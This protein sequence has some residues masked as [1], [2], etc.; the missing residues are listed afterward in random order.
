VR[1]EIEMQVRDMVAKDIDV[2]LVGIGGLAQGAGDAGEDCAQRGGFW[3]VQ[4]G[5]E[6][7][8]AAGLKVGESGDRPLRDAGEP[9]PGVLP[10]EGALEIS[11]GGS[12]ITQ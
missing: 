2:D 9:P 11:V 3:P 5:D 1:G 12:R 4:F 10:H 8:V 7:D 6:R